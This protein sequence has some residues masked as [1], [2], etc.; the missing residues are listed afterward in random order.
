M[1]YEVLRVQV[2]QSVALVLDQIRTHA[3][4]YLNAIHISHCLIVNP[5]PN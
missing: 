4:H 1:L 5:V 3:G 2:K